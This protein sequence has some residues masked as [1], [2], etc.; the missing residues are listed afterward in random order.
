MR[1]KVVVKLTADILMTFALF[2]QMGYMFWGDLAHEWVGAGMS[3]L[4]IIHHI[5]NANWHKNIFRGRYSPYRVFMLIIDAAVFLSMIGLMVSG[6]MLSNHVFGFLGISGGISFARLLHMVS[7]YWGFVLMSMHLG[8]HWG[9]LTGMLKKALKFNQDSGKVRIVFIVIGAAIA[10]YGLIAFIRRD[11]L[12]YMLLQT[13][14]VFMDFSEPIILFYLDYF[15]MMGT[16]VFAGHYASVFF[17]RP[18][19]KKTLSGE[20]K[21][22]AY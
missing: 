10:I 17:R 4:F 14:F 2:F 20:T 21:T 16:F 1:P 13:E 22:D 7:A 5:L 15:A 8:L 12:T 9:M 18:S 11:I 6:I 19:G 3:I